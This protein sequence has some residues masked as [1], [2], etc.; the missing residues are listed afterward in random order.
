MIGNSNEF[1]LPCF[2]RYL[3]DCTTIE[4]TLGGEG[5]ASSGFSSKQDADAEVE[6][7]ARASISG[8]FQPIRFRSGQRSDIRTESLS[9]CLFGLLKSPAEPA[10]LKLEVEMAFFCKAP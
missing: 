9:L 1:N 7:K 10:D 4:G 2:S 6:D 3:I 8:D 5:I